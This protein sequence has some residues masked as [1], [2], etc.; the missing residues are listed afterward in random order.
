MKIFNSPFATSP[1]LD[2]S[3][4]RM[5][6]FTSKLLL[7]IVIVV[8][9]QSFLPL[10]DLQHFSSS[11]TYPSYA[12]S[13]FPPTLFP[14]ETATPFTLAQH[15]SLRQHQIFAVN[16]IIVSSYTSWHAS[17]RILA[18]KAYKNGHKYHVRTLVV[19]TDA[20]NIH[21]LAD[22]LHA[23]LYAYICAVI[24]NRLLL[25]SWNEPLP[26][27]IFFNNSLGTNFTYDESVFSP[28]VFPNGT[29]D[30]KIITGQYLYDKK[31]E[32]DSTQTLYLDSVPELRV[33]DWFHAPSRRN[34]TVLEE[35]TKIGE[36]QQY[37]IF[38]LIFRVLFSSTDALRKKLKQSTKR[39]GMWNLVNNKKYISIHAHLNLGAGESYEG[40]KRY[41]LVKNL[42]MEAMAECYA[43]EAVKVAKRRKMEESPVFF[44][45]TD[46]PEFKSLLREALEKRMKKPKVFIGDW[47]VKDFRDLASG[48]REDLTKHMNMFL[49]IF[50]LASAD[51]IVYAKSGFANL[52]IWM[53]GIEDQTLVKH[54]QCVQY[55]I[56]PK[57]MIFDETNQALRIR[58]YN[59]TIR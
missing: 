56:V 17:Q 48:N 8:T 1:D 37:E 2:R 58:V 5:V 30:K 11:I 59:K 26:L 12:S 41:S 4:I 27:S 52:A 29:K 45:A 15:D 57:S 10:Y 55:Q 40:G 21:G 16:K 25:I 14:F 18:E 36:L 34:N 35:L 9:L 3:R 44:V 7:I 31:M 53:G 23:I 50:L 43:V 46:S 38:P 47:D 22:R 39:L 20:S 6:S 24:S 42:S 28:F 32:I 19:R 51:A 49:D 13:S 54:G 33:R